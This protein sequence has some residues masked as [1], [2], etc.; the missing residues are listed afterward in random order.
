M[1]RSL[2]DV[3]SQTS[4]EAREWD[5]RAGNVGNVGLNVPAPVIV[6]VGIGLLAVVAMRQE[7]IALCDEVVVS[8]HNTDR[9]CH[10]DDVAAEEVREAF[11]GGKNLP[12]ADHP[13]KRQAEELSSGDID[14]SR[15][16]HRAVRAERNHVRCDICAENK[17]SPER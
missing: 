15:T 1:R 6:V 9:G 8:D 16:E 11:G 10:E 7:D 14:V 2:T 5:N 3:G 12:G 17:E 4:A 13:S